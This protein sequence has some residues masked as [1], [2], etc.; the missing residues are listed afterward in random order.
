MKGRAAPRGRIPGG[1]PSTGG[2]RWGLLGQKPLEHSST[3]FLRCELPSRNYSARLGPGG[4]PLG[5]S[6]PPLHDFPH[7]GWECGRVSLWPGV[8]G[9]ALV[10]PYLCCCKGSWHLLLHI[11]EGSGVPYSC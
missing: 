6:Q 1:Q 9:L 2:R 4:L 5:G 8:Q 11:K 3:R 7:W 10:V